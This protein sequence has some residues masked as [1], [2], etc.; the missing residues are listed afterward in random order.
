[1]AEGEA[2]FA[3]V[4]GVRELDELHVIEM[5]ATVHSYEGANNAATS[6]HT[7]ERGLISTEPMAKPPSRGPCPTHLN[8]VRSRVCLL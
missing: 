5:R 3:A 4:D 6:H 7:N 1:M 2:V 8:S